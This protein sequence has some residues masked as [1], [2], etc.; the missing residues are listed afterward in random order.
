MQ[1]HELHDLSNDEVVQILYNGLN[2]VEEHHVFT[3]YSPAYKSDPANLFFILDDKNGRYSMGNGTYYVVEED[4]KYVSSAGW[5]RYTDDIALCMTRLYVDKE[6]R[7]NYFMGNLLLPRMFEE[8]KDY[9][10]VWMTFN[11][12]NKALYDWISRKNT[13][14]KNIWPDIW[15]RFEPIGIQSVYN[16]QQYVVQLN[17]D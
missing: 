2:R 15:F 14:G 10:K 17:N 3:N 1:V 6:Y 5:N 13:D 12:Y 8:T 9:K 16:T 11:R 7:S 4:G